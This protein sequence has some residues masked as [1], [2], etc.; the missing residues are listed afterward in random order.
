LRRLAQEDVRTIASKMAKNVI[1][2]EDPI[3][4]SMSQKQNLESDERE[5]KIIDA[6]FFDKDRD[7]A[8]RQSAA[9][10]ARG[11]VPPALTGAV[12]PTDEPR[13]AT[14]G[15]PAASAALNGQQQHQSK[16][17]AASPAHWT[18]KFRCPAN[19]PFR[20]FHR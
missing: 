7:P 13:Y 2:L 16:D 14:C 3:S 8:S 1:V 4:I 11:Y 10:T 20:S 17:N 12:L 15:A 18:N 9:P 6:L 5:R 19:R